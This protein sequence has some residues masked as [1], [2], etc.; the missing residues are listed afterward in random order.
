MSTLDAKM[1]VR[2][3][4]NGVIVTTRRTVNFTGDRIQVTDNKEQRRIDVAVS[5]EVAP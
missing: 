1:K 3:M 5:D 4:V 2:I